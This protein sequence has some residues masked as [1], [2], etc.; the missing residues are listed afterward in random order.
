MENG[1]WRVKDEG[2]R[3]EDGGENGRY[4]VGRIYSIC[5]GI[6][7][8]ALSGN[9]YAPYGLYISSP[10]N[11]ASIINETLHCAVSVR[12]ITLTHWPLLSWGPGSQQGTT[13]QSAA[14]VG[15]WG[16]LPLSWASVLSTC[17]PPHEQAGD[18]KCGSEC[19]HTKVKIIPML[20]YMW[21]HYR[22][23]WCQLQW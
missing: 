2:G 1:G 16:E 15:T 13:P 4:T 14:D 7:W 20:Y 22:T 19:L 10:S 21:T 8:Q 9:I 11:T 5:H 12:G 18:L 6:Y 23:H 3:I 17:C